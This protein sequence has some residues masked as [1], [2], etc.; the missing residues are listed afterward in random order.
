MQ[1]KNCGCDP[2]LTALDFG[3]GFDRVQINHSGTVSIIEWFNSDKDEQIAR[4]NL[5]AC[6]AR[7]LAE[8]ILREA[9]E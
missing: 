2:E 5:D 9:R 1:C 6:D 3:G 8:F 4:I 7:K